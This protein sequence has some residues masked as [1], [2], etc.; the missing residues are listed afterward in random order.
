MI[1]KSSISEELPSTLR[2]IANGY[3]IFAAP[4]DGWEIVSLSPHRTQNQS[5][6]EALNDR[7]R[8]LIYSVAAGLT[9][10]QISRTLHISEGSVKL[11]L[12]RLMDELNVS[13]RVQLAVIA[14]ENGL[15]TSA[16]LKTA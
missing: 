2:L 5:I 3:K 9:N 7:D 6:I 15:I 14:T 16:D 12:A 4:H 11:H 8:R 10:T 1:S 13:N